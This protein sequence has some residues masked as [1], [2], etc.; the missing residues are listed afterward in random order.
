[1]TFWMMVSN[2]SGGMAVPVWWCGRV[3]AE[4]RRTSLVEGVSGMSD[5]AGPPPYDPDL[6]AIRWIEDPWHG[7]SRPKM[8]RCWLLFWRKCPHRLA[9]EEI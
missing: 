7:P 3:R 1:M 9:A 6:D 5:P 4:R 8:W 2:S